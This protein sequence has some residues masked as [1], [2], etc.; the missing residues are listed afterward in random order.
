MVRSQLA[1]Y[2]QQFIYKLLYL[3]WQVGQT[4]QIGC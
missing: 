3:A 4:V 1:G 2:V